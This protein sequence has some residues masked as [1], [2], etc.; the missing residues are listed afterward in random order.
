MPERHTVEFREL[1]LNILSDASRG[2]IVLQVDRL[3]A[4]PGAIARLER[5]LRGRFGAGLAARLRRHWRGDASPLAPGPPARPHPDNVDVICW[6]IAVRAGVRMD[7]A[8]GALLRFC[9]D[10]P[11]YLRTLGAALDADERA[12]RA[13]QRPADPSSRARTVLTEL[14]RRHQPR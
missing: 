2:T 11:G 7:D 6:E 13:P 9:R 12:P 14:F 4:R 5:A 10:Q 8:L 1:C 3:D